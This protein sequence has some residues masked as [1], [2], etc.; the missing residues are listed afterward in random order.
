MLAV[1]V[2]Q[3][4]KDGDTVEVGASRWWKFSA[5]TIKQ[6]GD[7]LLAFVDGQVCVGAFEIVGSEPDEAEGGKYVFDLR[8]ASRFQWALGKKLP[9]PPGRNPVRILSGQALREFLDSDPR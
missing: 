8:P 9:L 7:Y 2:R 6:H 4:L 1:D 5:D 3:S